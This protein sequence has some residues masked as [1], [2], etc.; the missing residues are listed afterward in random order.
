MELTV[1]VWAGGDCIVH[2]VGATIRERSDVMNLEEWN[3][4][5]VL[6]WRSFATYLATAVRP[7]SHPGIY[8]RITLETGCVHEDLWDVLR[9]G[10][11]RRRNAISLLF[12]S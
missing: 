4:V 2:F 11:W 5:A 7:P 12:H 10:G 1:A 9:T 6:K 8:L 3:V